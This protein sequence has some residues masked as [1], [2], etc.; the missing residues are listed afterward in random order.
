MKFLIRWSLVLTILEISMAMISLGLSGI[1]LS[2]DH[3]LL[4]VLFRLLKQ[5]L[6]WSMAEINHN[7]VHNM[8][9][10]VII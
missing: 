10:N 2:V 1:K 3:A 9:F 4:W 8:L 7:W 6:S 5:G